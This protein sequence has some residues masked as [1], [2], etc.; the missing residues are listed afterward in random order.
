MKRET[1]LISALAFLLVTVPLMFTQDPRSQP[2]PA[3]RSD[4]LGP[5]LIAWSQAQRPQPVP[6]PLPAAERFVPDQQSEPPNS[7][8]DPSTAA[9]T[10]SAK[11][12]GHHREE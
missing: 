8:D 1:G 12:H 6:Q 4:I 9:A 7:P 11:V 5:Q 3:P 10:D 2:S